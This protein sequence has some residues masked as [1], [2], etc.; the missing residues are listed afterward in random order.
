[1]HPRSA[2]IHW[3]SEHKKRLKQESREAGI[4]YSKHAAAEWAKV[5]DKSKWEDLAA[6]DKEAYAEEKPVVHEVGYDLG[7]LYGIGLISIMALGPQAATPP[8]KRLHPLEH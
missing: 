3:Q 1:M 6:A 5:D 2:F 8:P 4:R 7:R